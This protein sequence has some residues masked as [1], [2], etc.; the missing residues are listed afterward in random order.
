MSSIVDAAKSIQAFANGS[1]RQKIGQLEKMFQGK[2]SHQIADLLP[3][4]AVNSNLLIAG[5]ALKQVVGQINVLIHAVGI[6]I[7]LPY[8]MEEGE[9]IEALSL[10]AGNTG[11]PFDVETN[12]EIA[13]FE[14]YPME[15]GCKINPSKFSLQRFFLFSGI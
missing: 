12:Q 9:V 3:K 13:E 1:L 7:C 4:I 6:L 8:V 2:D 14:I 10:G 5:I 11:R 15:R